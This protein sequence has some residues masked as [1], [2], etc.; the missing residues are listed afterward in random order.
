MVH[1]IE[2]INAIMV[3]VRTGQ[4]AT[5]H[6]VPKGRSRLAL[7]KRNILA[8]VVRGEPTAAS[9]D[10]AGK[11]LCLFSKTENQAVVY[12]FDHQYKKL[13]QAAQPLSF[14]EHRVEAVFAT[15]IPRKKEILIQE[16]NG[17]IRIFD[18]AFNRFNS[19][20]RVSIPQFGIG[21]EPVQLL[22][23]P[24]G[25]MLVCLEHDPDQGWL[26][27]SYIL[28]GAGAKSILSTVREHQPLPAQLR[29]LSA[30][31]KFE[32]CVCGT[33]THFVG[34]DPLDKRLA[35]IV[36]DVTSH[37]ASN[38]LWRENPE[39]QK[40]V[41]ENPANAMLNF[42]YHI[43]DKFPAAPVMGDPL[44]PTVMWLAALAQ[45]EGPCPSSK[46]KSIQK[47]GENLLED[48]KRRTQKPFGAV[49]LSWETRPYWPTAEDIIQT[50]RIGVTSQPF[51]ALVTKAICLVP[52]QICRC[53]NNALMPLKDGLPQPLDCDV[54]EVEDVARQ[55]SFGPY[56]AIFQSSQK[57][58]LVV[59]SMGA[60]STGKS[61]Q[62]NHLGGTL[63]DVSGGRCTDG[64]W[65]SVREAELG[66]QSV[67]MVYLDCE[68]LGSWERTESED[69]LLALVSAAMASLTMFK[70]HF[71]F[72]RYTRSTLERFNQGAP[73]VKAMCGVT[74]HA[75]YK[76][77]FMFA[78]KDT[79]DSN[80]EEVMK[81]FGHKTE[82]LL[83]EE[84]NFL[85]TMF[86]DGVIF[87]A[88]PFL[89]DP[90][91]YE[92]L[93]DVQTILE[94]FKPQFNNPVN[95]AAMSKTLL[96]KI[97][98]KDWTP[99]DRNWIR[100]R[101]A[102][103][104]ANL[105]AACHRG[106]LA[107]VADSTIED[108][109]SPL[110]NFDTE[111]LL[112]DGPLNFMVHIS[113]PEVVVEM[114]DVKISALE[115]GAMDTDLDDEGEL[116]H[117]HM[118]NAECLDAGIVLGRPAE[119]GGVNPEVQDN[120]NCL[121]ATFSRYFPAQPRTK[122]E[123]EIYHLNFSSFLAV[124]V[125]RRRARVAAWLKANMEHFPEDPEAKQML[126]KQRLIMDELQQLFAVCGQQCSHCFMLCTKFKRHG[127]DHDC[128]QA[129]HT[130]VHS[131]K[132]CEAD[133]WCGNPVPC[134]LPSGHSGIH[135]CGSADHVCG[136]DCALFNMSWNCMQRC[137]KPPGHEGA[138]DCGS[139]NHMCGEECSLDGCTGKCIKPVGDTHDRHE[140]ASRSCP[141]TCAL[142]NL[143]CS[144]TNHFHA[145]MGPDVLHLCGRPHQCT[146]PKTKRPKQCSF[147]GV[148]E[149]KAELRCETRTFS[150]QRG[151]FDYEFR[152]QQT[153]H[154]HLCI[155]EIPPGE[156]HHQGPCT[157]NSDPHVLH[158]CGHQC[159]S[160]QYMCSLQFGH[161]GPHA[162]QHG[163]MV[164][165]VFVSEDKDIDVGPRKYVQG[166]SGIAETCDSFC[167]SC[168][169]GHVH[170]IPCDKT[171]CG[172][173]LCD[174]RR[175]ACSKYAD[176]TGSATEV[177]ELTH[178][179]YWENID[180]KDPCTHDQQR[181]FKKCNAQCGSIIHESQKD[182][183][184]DPVVV[185]CSLPLWHE[186]CQ[187]G[188]L[189]H[190]ETAGYISQNGHFFRCSHGGGG[191]GCY[192]TYFIIDRS[193]S[194]GS[195]DVQPQSPQICNAV[196]FNNL[197]N[198]LGVVYE[199]MM[200]Y[201]STRK[202]VSPGDTI[203]FVPFHQSADVIF[204]QLSITDDLQALEYMMRVT[205]HGGT[206]FT[207]GIQKAHFQLTSDD[208]RGTNNGRTPVFILLT[209]SG[210]FYPAET[211]RLVQ[212]IMQQE[213]GTG[214]KMHCLGF[215]NQVDSAYMEQLAGVGQ[216]AFHNN[217]GSNDLARLDLVSAFQA[218]AEKPDSKAALMIRN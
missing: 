163:N 134:E 32:I 52:I 20:L 102:L 176:G 204:S 177:D 51:G 103:L 87:A 81:E 140:C 53:E 45:Q 158:Y 13:N 38:S 96:A 29:T 215:G 122:R 49:N 101:V 143:T 72:N 16:A 36:I 196:G 14:A 149:I 65:L 111:D 107:A 5:V 175:H 127:G 131:C 216:G 193:G 10:A 100:G 1:L 17:T 129:S 208:Q 90:A 160:C 24:D 39:E 118:A 189:P 70:T 164:S 174:G 91:F 165:T 97:A 35:S 25:S 86:P 9:Y 217:L 115:S 59:T 79:Q 93:G 179:A 109:P 63:F 2:P 186:P 133:E 123:F 30:E 68:G 104:D 77:K 191:G 60:Q 167:N 112:P 69:M 108:G 155:V 181:L 75:L 6:A 105:A 47:Y 46:L 170:V 88:F 80:A 58:V 12:R 78:L 182:A 43:F 66:G 61:Y 203:T 119:E 95:F 18:F 192:A 89:E 209:D 23:T 194:M 159:P 73:K 218:L 48:V 172:S 161:T 212:S 4:G 33:K 142:C 28:E 156:D 132:Y 11:F 199:A 125:E 83:Q 22:T 128:L 145:D 98:H 184:G 144:S 150:G 162:T 126:Q 121:A 85:S 42:L 136:K 180:F 50:S 130:C 198:R 106:T 135:N 214:L 205:P 94:N 210:D 110:C 71:D 173:L 148:C 154:R 64:C 67:L 153:V 195:G 166:E 137:G 15:L 19:T 21:G 202:A 74:Q 62:L 152:T 57:P 207:C 185:Y 178:E 117:T 169:R 82:A 183:S 99:L 54:K 200:T 3:V 211:L 120:L 76:G 41:Q 92:A 116:V 197:R 187:P 201:I 113:N 55:I 206:Q 7:E 124:V 141:V 8:S 40:D 27:T 213:A 37:S 114:C 139:G 44:S 188:V 190:G 31:S 84:E 157:H 138:C 171:Q 26:L 34:M 151:N 146:D 168:G 56:E 147:D